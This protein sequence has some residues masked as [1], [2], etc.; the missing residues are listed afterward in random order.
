MEEVTTS[1][2]ECSTFLQ[3]SSHLFLSTLKQEQLR[4]TFQIQKWKFQSL[5]GLSKINK[6]VRSFSWVWKLCIFLHIVPEVRH[7][8]RA[9]AETKTFDDK[10]F[11]SHQTM[12]VT[13]LKFFHNHLYMRCSLYS[14]GKAVGVKVF[15]PILQIRKLRC[16]E[17]VWDLTQ[18][19]QIVKLSSL[20]LGLILPPALFLATFLL[21]FS[22]MFQP[23]LQSWF[24]CVK[25]LNQ[26][27]SFPFL[28]HQKQD[29]QNSHH[30]ASRLC[31]SLWALPPS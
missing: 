17:W 3:R 27:V 20:L 8:E 1:L 31:Y 26:C 21:S 18:L 12:F 2:P 10:A 13:I 11:V 22:F 19:T 4:L 16:R 28:Q 7:L 30:V 6:Q 5:Y 14:P 9:V 25:S 29:G 24:K 15:V 23:H